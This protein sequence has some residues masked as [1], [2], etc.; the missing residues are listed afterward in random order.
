M[1][2]MLDKFYELSAHLN[3]LLNSDPAEAV[4]QA[5]AIDLDTPGRFNLMSLRAA[6]LVDGGALTQQ[7]DAIEEGVAFFRELEG[8]FPAVVDI[9]YNLANG[10]VA[11][12]GNPP[13]DQGWLDHQERTREYR[14]EARRCYWRVT[15]NLDADPSLKTQS[16]T[17]LANQLGSSLRLGEAHDARLAALE[18]DPQNGVAAYAAA[19]DLLW[20]FNQ[21][22]CSDLT[23]IEAVMLAKIAHR[24]QDRVVLYAG[25]QA[26]KQIAEFASELGDPPPR[27]LHK[28]PFISWVERERLTLAPV[29][30]L[31][32]PALGKLDWLMLP[33]IL[34][35]ELGAGARPPPVFA[36]FNVLKSDFILARDLAWRAIDESVWPATG[37]FSDTLDYATYGPDVSALVLAHRTAL[38]LLDKV[39]VTA[40]HYFDF[41]KK[42]NQIYFCTL[43]RGRNN[44][45]TGVLPLADKVDALIRTGVS[46][47]YGLVELADDYDSTLGILRS[48]KDLRNAG[49]H[50]FVVLHDLSDPSHS[51]QAPEIEHHRLDVFTQEVLRALRVARSAIQML[52]LAISQHERGMAQREN[53]FVGSLIVPDHDWIRGRDEEI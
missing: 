31:V 22:G 36:M 48:Q 35:R 46:A 50:R 51:R 43:W 32:D 15:Q 39:A 44:K 41:G 45:T 29:V 38:D 28:D 26:A 52:A 9:T 17:N 24:H 27:A 30:E 11:S 37:R 42:P 49:T 21:G 13:S 3:A 2:S 19:R 34:E 53:G 10:L 40:N 1:S 8:Q 5:R 14:A 4:K 6:I 47:L 18:I 25:A 20:L 12:V 16:W 7:Q 23:R 33:G